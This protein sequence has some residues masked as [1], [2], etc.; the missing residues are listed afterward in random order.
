MSKISIDA[1][2]DLISGTAKYSGQATFNAAQFLFERRDRNLDGLIRDISDS[3]VKTSN[4][5]RLAKGIAGGIRCSLKQEGHGNLVNDAFNAIIQNSKEWGISSRVLQGSLILDESSNPERW[6]IIGTASGSYMQPVEYTQEC[7]KAINCMSEFYFGELMLTNIGPIHPYTATTLA[8][9][10][11]SFEQKQQM[12]I[13][14]EEEQVIK[15]LLDSG[16]LQCELP[17]R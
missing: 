15:N 7:L 5:S 16:F 11:P 3:N 8:D 4:L 17:D 6:L 13:L 12:E 1:I 2:K 14:S 10:S 9:L